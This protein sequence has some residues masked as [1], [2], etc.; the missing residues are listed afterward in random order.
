MG[1][2]ILGIETSCDETAAAVVTDGQRVMSNVVASQAELHRCFG[3]VVPE[4]ASRRHI[5][6]LNPVIATALAEAGL[7][8]DD[9]NAIAVTQGPGLLGSLLVGLMAAKS[10]SFALKIPLIAVNHIEAHIY[11]NFLLGEEIS[12]PFVA[13]VVSG[14]HTDIVYARSHSEMRLVGQTLDDA[15]GE[16]FDKVARF[17]GLGYPGGPVIES[18]ARK[19]NPEAIPLP[20]AFLEEGSLDTSFSGLKTAVVNHINRS[21]QKGEEVDLSDVAASFQAAVVEILVTKALAAVETYGAKALL[22]AGGVAA[23][24]HLRDVM[25]TRMRMQDVK[26]VIPP[27]ALCTDNAAM[28][29]AA[30]YYRYLRG[31]FAP[32]EINA[33]AGLSL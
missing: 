12:F 2:L 22:L 27:P 1:V 17:L 5:E 31:D 3:G 8:F 10:L 24:G 16:A 25:L 15:A 19:G 11:A 28:V 29:A 13:M 32:L 30:G 7:G 33:A 6:T 14:G 18:L 21:R 23:N 4:V 20:R 9:L 26:V